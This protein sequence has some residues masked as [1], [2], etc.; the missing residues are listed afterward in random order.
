[1]ATSNEDLGTQLLG[2]ERQYWQAMKDQDVD[3]A[4]RLSEDPCIVT[5]AQG[6]ASIDGKTL[7]SMIENAN[8]TV[9]DFRLDDDV[10]VRMLGEDVAI[11][12]YTVHE[13]ITVD[14]EPVSLD[15]ADASTWVR[16]DG[17]WRCALH[18]ETLLGD[19]FGR[20]RTRPS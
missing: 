14:G 9:R 5:G 20:D 6:V 8:Y 1:M 3:A 15:A 19:P 17:Q 13:E 2:L 4:R 11:L 7:A 16:R 10:H 18:T 12:A